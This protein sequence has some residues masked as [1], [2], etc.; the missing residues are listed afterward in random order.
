MFSGNFNIVVSIADEHNYPTFA[1]D[2]ICARF[3]TF[4]GPFKTQ[5]CMQGILNRKC[6]YNNLLASAL[7]VFIP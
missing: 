6:V 3:D 4:Y 5:V 1:L 7:L 2:N